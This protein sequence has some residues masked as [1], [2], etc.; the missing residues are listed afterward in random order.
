ML[1]ALFSGV[2]SFVLRIAMPAVRAA[3]QAVL[4]ELNI[5]KQDATSATPHAKAAKDIDDE[6]S[7]MERSAARAGRP[8]SSRDE[9]HIDELNR[10]RPRNLQTLKKL[11]EQRWRRS[12]PPNL[13]YSKHPT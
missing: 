6:I 1:E 10:K 4:K 2:A 3:I 9:E 11:K 13:I 5:T 12:W 7:D 8:L